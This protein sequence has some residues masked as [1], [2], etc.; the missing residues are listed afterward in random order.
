MAGICSSALCD[1]RRRPLAACL[2]SIFTLSAPGAA[3]ASNWHV[4][5]CADSGVGSLRAVVGAVTTLSNDSV[6]L[7]GLSCPSSKI[8]LATGAIVVA[9]DSL[10]IT[11]PGISALVIDGSTDNPGLYG[12]FRIFTHTGSGTLTV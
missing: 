10:T 6:D 1:S 12:D 4:I 11:G 5:S 2:A 9:Q 7:S 8:S 3:I